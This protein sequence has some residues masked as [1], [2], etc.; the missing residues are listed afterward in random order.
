M[1]K[2]KKNL[3]FHFVMLIKEVISVCNGRMTL[4]VVG[5][6]EVNGKP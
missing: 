1:F 6:Y 4:F 5:V 2:M 3:V